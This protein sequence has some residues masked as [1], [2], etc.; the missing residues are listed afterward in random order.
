M[1][2]QQPAARAEDTARQTLNE[3]LP[4]RFGILTNGEP[5][6]SWQRDCVAVLKQTDSFVADCWLLLRAASHAPLVDPLADDG[7]GAHPPVQELSRHCTLRLTEAPNTSP[8]LSAESLEAVSA[9]ALH[10]IVSF[11]EPA[12]ARPLVGRCRWG[13]WQFFFGDWQKYR[14]ESSGFWE[15]VDDEPCAVAML[16][17]LQTDAHAVRILKQGRIRSHACMPTMTQRR[18]EARCAHWPLQVCLEAL[19]DGGAPFS[20]AL[21]RAETYRERNFAATIKFAV[22]ATWRSAR[23]VASELLRHEQW[24]VGLID[25]PIDSLLATSAPLSPRWL[26]RPGRNEFFADPFAVAHEGRLFVFC[27]YMDY[28]V[29]RGRIVVFT[30][31]S[32]ESVTAVEIGPPVHLSYPYLLQHE[33]RLYCIPETQEANEIALYELERFPQRWRRVATLVAGARFIDATIFRYDG[34]WWLA[35]SMPAPKGAEC[36]LH[37]YYADSLAG[38]WQPHR[39]NPVK[40]DVQS[41][42][43]AGTPFWKDGALYRPTQDC[44][45]EY[46]GRVIINRVVKLTRNSYSEEYCCSVDPD[47]SSRYR[48]GLHTLSAAGPVTL[49]D[50]KRHIFVATEFMT[51]LRLM[52]RGLFRMSGTKR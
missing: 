5:L 28:R 33:G 46:G 32:P 39:A 51:V 9:R 47:K 16:A 23:E 14:G 44:S 20:S 3:G 18:L 52:V 42:R 1:R 11:V 43:P 27:E 21:V 38:S 35:A 22:R 6:A 10:F 15:I 41:A 49:I 31:D 12:A 29:G 40:V 34:A 13:I 45:R 2:I 30:T 36:E 37:L 24:N 4:L 50:A 25:A 19:E 48:F 26:Q 17:Q 7:D 8:S